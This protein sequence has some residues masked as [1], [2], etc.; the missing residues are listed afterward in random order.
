M[1]DSADF[2]NYILHANPRLTEFNLDKEV[3]FLNL[4]LI[5]QFIFTFGS[6]RIFF[7]ARHYETNTIVGPGGNVLLSNRILRPGDPVFVSKMEVHEHSVGTLW[8]H[9]WST[10][11]LFSPRYHMAPRRFYLDEQFL[12]RANRYNDEISN[13]SPVLVH[14]GERFVAVFIAIKIIEEG[15]ALLY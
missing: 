8:V 4:F 10:M 11:T 2:E 9:P 6:Q 15:D 3:K 1:N 7:A 13:I 12:R 5:F 14:T